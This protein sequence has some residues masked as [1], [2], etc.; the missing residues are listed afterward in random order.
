MK[1]GDLVYKITNEWQRYNKWID[2]PDEMPEMLG[3]IVSP[4]SEHRWSWLVL[5]TDGEVVEFN[6]KWLML[7]Q[8]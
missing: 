3:V 6:E 4:S 5:T 1:V 7:A 8:D 2:F